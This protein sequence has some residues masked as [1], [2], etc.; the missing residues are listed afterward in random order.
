MTRVR[1]SIAAH[2][3]LALMVAAFIAGLAA[4]VLIYFEPQKLFIDD[5]VNEALPT[6]VAQTET[7]DPA[8][9]PK[10]DRPKTLASGEFRSLEHAS[11]GRALLLEIGDKRYLRFENFETSNGP[12]LRVYLSA[13]PSTSGEDAFDDDYVELGELKGNIGNQNY[14][15]PDSVDLA[16]FKSAVVWCK[17][18]SAGFAVAPVEDA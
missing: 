2:P 7:R 3:L 12:D 10:P 15:V 13:A 18:F 8:A 16:R 6:A 11:S 1:T 5:E 4:F 9:R 14:A 17:R